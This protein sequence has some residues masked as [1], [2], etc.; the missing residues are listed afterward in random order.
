MDGILLQFY[1]GKDQLNLIN[2]EC[3]ILS[4]EC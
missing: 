3:F 4:F 1:F 2:V